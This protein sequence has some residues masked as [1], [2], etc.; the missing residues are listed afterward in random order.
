MDQAP[1]PIEYHPSERSIRTEML[2][3]GTRFILPT[4]QGRVMRIGGGC[5]MASSVFFIGFAVFWIIV[6]LGFGSGAGNRP[7][8]FTIFTYVFAAAGLLPLLTGLGI[9]IAGLGMLAGWSRCEVEITSDQLRVVERV[10]PLRKTFKRK[11]SDIHKLAIE[12]SRRSRGREPVGPASFGPQYAIIASGEA[13]RPLLIGAAYPLDLLRELTGSLRE[14]LDLDEDAVTLDVPSIM[15]QRAGVATGDDT[16]QPVRRPAGANISIEHN[17]DELNIF[18]PPTGLR[19]GSKGLFVFSLLWLGFITVF[20]IV[21]IPAW[22]SRGGTDRLV[23]LFVLPFWAIGIAMLLGAINMGRRRAY[24]D[25]V[26]GT[27]LIS[28]KGIFGIKQREFDLNDI[29][30]I[31]AGPS[32]MEVNDVP[33]LELQIHSK[34]SG[35]YGLLSQRDDDELRWLAYELRTFLARTGPGT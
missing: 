4:R 31:Q 30:D 24:I 20:S 7:A 15:R 28:R 26:A 6:S 2:A 21:W 18:V 22:W 29:A 32:G 12:L 14:E 3:N 23:A 13:G 1:L 16:E 27:L 35:K 5:M 25:V 8:G 34:S 33:V 10:G 11:A 17:G 19:K 9:F